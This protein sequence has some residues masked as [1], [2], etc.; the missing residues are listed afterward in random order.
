MPSCKIQNAPENIG[1]DCAYILHNNLCRLYSADCNVY[2]MI[3][4]E[5]F[6][7]HF[8]VLHC[9]CI[10]KIAFKR[11]HFWRLHHLNCILLIVFCILQFADCIFWLHFLNFTFRFYFADSILLFVFSRLYLRILFFKHNKVFWG[12]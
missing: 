1:K 12:S 4:I 8:A 6:N 2:C 10:L 3:H 5:A 9:I 11:L 7:F